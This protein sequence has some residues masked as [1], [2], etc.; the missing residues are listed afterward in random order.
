[1]IDEDLRLF[2]RD[3]NSFV[4][5]SHEIIE[6]N[7]A[8]I[9]LS[10]LPFTPKDSLVRRTFLDLFTGLPSIETYGINDH[11]G[12]CV[13]V[14]AETDWSVKSVTYSP[15]SKVLALSLNDNTVRL[16]DARSGVEICRLSTG[17]GEEIRSIAFTPDGHC[18][19]AGTENGNAFRWDTRT[20]RLLF[21]LHH[22]HTNKITT[23]VLSSDGGKIASAFDNRTIDVWSTDT[24]QLVCVLPG[25]HD[26]SVFAMAFSPDGKTLASGGDDENVRLWDYR[27]GELVGE[28]FTGHEGRV[29]ALAFSL[30]GVFLASGSWDIVV[31]IWD[32]HTGQQHRVYSSH[33][34]GVASLAFAP[35]GNALASA[36]SDRTVH[37]WNIRDDGHP[38]S[39]LVLRGHSEDVNCVCF[40]ND[41]LYV[42]SC[43]D[44]TI[45]VWDVGGD[46][47]SVPPLDGHA[48]SVNAIAV[49]GDSRLIAS[50]S[51]DGSVRVWD[52]HTYEQTYPLLRH[53]GPVNSVTFSSDSCLIA[54]GS[55][56]TMVRLWDA[57]T[58]Q[59]AVSELRG[60]NEEVNTVAFSM[61][62][63]HLAS[64]SD[65]DTIRVWHVSTTHPVQILQIE[66]G[67]PVL[68][69][70]YSSNGTLI[71][72]CSFNAHIFNA[73]TGQMV[74]SLN[75]MTGT[76]AVSPDGARIVAPID[77]GFIC[78]DSYTG[79]E[80]F[81]AEDHIKYS[82]TVA[83]S[84]DGR[85]IASAGT[86]RAVHLRN[87]MTAKAIEP[88]LRGHMGTIYSVVFSPDGRFLVTGS[89]DA[90]IRIWD[91]EQ[92]KLLVNQRERN[93]LES[94]AFAKYV[95]Y[96]DRWLVSPTNDRLLWVPPEYRGYLEIAGLSRILATRR[97]VITAEEGIMH[98]GEQWAQC[99]RSNNSSSS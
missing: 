18:L 20:G 93:A 38:T 64:G 72:A 55:D 6:Y 98:Q 49:S 95:K 16:W 53:T 88:V 39:P 28:P 81:H 37:I 35:D 65:D 33:K 47:S 21:S 43:S 8:H 1:M 11:A 25:G 67:H 5:S 84:P 69:V 27:L 61:D 19:T 54:T 15:D 22:Q 31:R 71:A 17:T 26:G 56:D 73:A 59:L 4:T 12:R 66:C 62:D 10:A 48:D 76:L 13:M 96:N 36:S 42:A 45:R 85:C 3:A 79:A 70:A 87:A 7:A 30:D 44:D 58:G 23:V 50:A 9:Y 24:D 68:S 89:S 51:D 82:L 94:L 90:T 80:I 86:D 78:F 32:T 77:A 83:Y 52:A 34:D 75:Y 91:L 97:V 41:G 57:R 99:W 74:Q 2:L 29:S 14:V 92:V 46:Y 63:L 40:S 60:H